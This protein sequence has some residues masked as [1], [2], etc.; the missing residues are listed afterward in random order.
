VEAPNWSSEYQKWLL[1]A[2]TEYGVL[3]DEAT[4]LL[5]LEY[6]DMID[7]VVRD[8]GRGKI[9]SDRADGLTRSI[10]ARL[11][12][13]GERLG[14]SGDGFMREAAGLAAGGHAEGLA[15]ASAASGV[16]TS[17]SFT[18]IPDLA[19]D[20]MASRR[21]FATTFRTLVNRHIEAMAPEVEAFVRSAVAR[22]VSG[23]RAGQ[24][25]AAMMSRNDPALLDVL[26]QLG[27]RGGRT[28]AAIE[29]GITFTD[30]E[31]KQARRLL[32]NARRIA[33]SETNN[34][35]HEAD[36]LA[37]SESPVVSL[38]QWTLSGRH[39][40]LPSSPD[41]CDICA[42]ADL[43]GFGPGLYFP[44]ALPPLQH[45]FC[46]CGS[47][48]ILRRPSEWN[49][50]KPELP[51]SVGEVTLQEA[52]RILERAS[53]QYSRSLTPRHITRQMEVANTLAR[54]AYD[55]AREVEV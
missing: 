29:A 24:E 18:E 11:R 13:L 45:P 7:A 54:N 2:R 16:G 34:A 38:L 5:Y 21:G 25:L 53:N 31:M 50:P 39:A 22:G 55:V 30:E 47:R 17:V 1:L 14:D 27:P 46:L 37:A 48:K 19:L 6:A 42:A 8:L 41:S 23:T 26:E 36:T 4:E 52:K 35:F 3:V 43:H 10:M 51:S 12:D 15:A 28:R 44:A 9:T 32:F 49:K 33:I 40:G 20:L